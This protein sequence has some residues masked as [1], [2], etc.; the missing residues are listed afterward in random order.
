MKV[1]KNKFELCTKLLKIKQ[2]DTPFYSFI[3]SGKV[4]KNPLQNGLCE[5]V[6]AFHQSLLKQCFI[7][8]LS[9]FFPE[10][11]NL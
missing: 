2:F 9:R 4:Q 6:F 1:D 8:R 5:K 10:F 11:E 3:S 7:F